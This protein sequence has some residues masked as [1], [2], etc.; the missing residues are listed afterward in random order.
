VHAALDPGDHVAG[1]DI[2]HQLAI[3]VHVRARL[4]R[5]AEL[6]RR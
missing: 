2:E 5:P 1:G 4:A 6:D 3:E